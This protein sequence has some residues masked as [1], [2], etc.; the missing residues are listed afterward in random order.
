MVYAPT[1]NAAATSK[2]A[3]PNLQCLGRRVASGDIDST[4]KDIGA[5]GPTLEIGEAIIAPPDAGIALFRA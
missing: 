3:R 1:T 4:A 2:K 5:K